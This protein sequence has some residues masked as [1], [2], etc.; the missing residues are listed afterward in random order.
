MQLTCFIKKQGKLFST[1]CLELDVASQGKTSEGARKNLK[2]AIDLYLEDVAESHNKKK[3][4]RRPA[5]YKI[6]QEYYK[7]STAHLVEEVKRSHHPRITFQ[8]VCA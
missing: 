4:L 1:I 5:P 2:E 7:A 3:F 6:W 8:P